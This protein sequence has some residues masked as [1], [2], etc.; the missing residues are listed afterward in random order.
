MR[1]GMRFALAAGVLVSLC[2]V[3]A[4]VQSHN[5]RAALPN[6]WWNSAAAIVRV[7]L[8]PVEPERSFP[9]DPKRAGPILERYKREGIS[10][11][12]IFAPYHGGH[13]FRGLDIINPFEIDPRIGTMED[14]RS[15]VR[16]IH[17]KGMAVTVFVNLG[18]ASAEAPE[19]LKAERDE[20]AGK[21]TAETRRFLWSN[22][23]DAT[24]PED[25]NNSYFLIG[26]RKKSFWAY[27]ARAGKYFWTTWEGPNLSGKVV[28]LPQY[29]W[30]SDEF[31]QRAVKIVRFWMDQGIDGMVVD[32]ANWYLGY[33]WQIGRKRITDVARSYGNAYLQPEGAGGFGDDPVAW[34]TEGGW[35]SVQDYGLGIWW[36]KNTDVLNQAIETGDPRPIE[37][38]LRDYH[39]RV[40]AAGGTLYYGPDQR[41]HSEDPAKTR[42][43]LATEALVGDLVAVSARQAMELDPEIAKLFRMKAAHPALYQA[44]AR[45]PLPTN[46]DDKYYAFLRTAAHDSERVLVVMNF[47]PE[48]EK[49]VVD[50]SGVLSRRLVD[51]LDGGVLEPRTRMSISVPAYGYR[52]FRVD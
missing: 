1:R 39:D 42:L 35:N 20:E 27:S 50:L 51:L 47:Q 30:R 40:V 3:Q 29:N 28:R 33:T 44:S 48:P 12:E 34:I 4:R 11:I 43:Y 23:V 7:S 14:F 13:S 25:G 37:R 26:D 16:L 22:R 15:L 21:T 38:K 36:K 5:G 2:S 49:I 41:P 18:Y 46:D 8:N 32:A 24:P 19:F 31:Q 9:I 17:G 45:R 6:E 10:A 52:L